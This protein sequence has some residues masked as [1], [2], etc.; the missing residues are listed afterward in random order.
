MFGLLIYEVFNGGSSHGGAAAGQTKNIPHAM[1]QSY[2]RLTNANPK[3]RLSVKQFLDQGCRSG[4]F[5]DTPLIH[6]TE[7]IDSMGLKSEAEREEFL[8]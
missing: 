7:G 5:F 8:K 3:A 2:K 1:E 6:L 4:G